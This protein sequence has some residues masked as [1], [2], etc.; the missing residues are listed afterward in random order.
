MVRG[1][2]LRYMYVYRHTRTIY[3]RQVYTSRLDAI[4]I[5]FYSFTNAP[6]RPHTGYPFASSS[7][8]CAWRS[9]NPAVET[10]GLR[11]NGYLD[12]TRSRKV[13]SPTA[14]QRRCL[15]PRE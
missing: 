6:F 8:S 1:V 10:R 12:Q 13:A 4:R 15:L 9:S 2:C 7:P 11:G 5:T 3:Q 14:L